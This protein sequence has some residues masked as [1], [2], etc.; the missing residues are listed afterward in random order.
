MFYDS[1][2][3][4]AALSVWV[5]L[6]GAP[7]FSFP[8]QVWVAGMTGASLH[9]VFYLPGAGPG[10]SYSVRMASKAREGKCQSMVIFKPLPIFT[11]VPLAKLSPTGLFREEYRAGI[12]AEGLEQS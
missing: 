2:A 4:W 8:A 10:V 12:Q 11:N 6:A 9:E 3:Q 5:S 7:Q 1:V